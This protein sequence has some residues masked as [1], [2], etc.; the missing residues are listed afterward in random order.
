[1]R[2]LQSC[3]CSFS[4]ER[5]ESFKWIVCHCSCVCAVWNNRRFPRQLIM[6]SKYNLCFLLFFHFVSHRRWT[7][8]TRLLLKHL[9]IFYRSLSFTSLPVIHYFSWC[10]NTCECVCECV[11][12]VFVS[13][14]YE[15]C[16][17]ANI[18]LLYKVS[19]FSPTITFGFL[20]FLH[21][22]FHQWC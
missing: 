5:E 15:S 13:L 12:R 2:K 1:M 7:L 4:T 14:L 3:N 9:K 19:F 6:L 11:C 20:S 18:H 17:M 22:S 16:K 21:V 8:T 10:E